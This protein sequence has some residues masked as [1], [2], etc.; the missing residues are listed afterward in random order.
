MLN[1]KPMLSFPARV[2]SWHA[3]AAIYTFVIVLA[4]CGGS[5][6]SPPT[7][8]PPTLASSFDV[9]KAVC[10]PG[11]R[12]E[13]GLQ[14]QIPMAER[15]GGF[16]G[17]NC[18]LEKTSAAPSSRGEGT[19]GMFALMHDRSGRTCGYTGGAF[20]DSIGTSVVDLTD[21]AKA[22]ETVVL[23]TAAMQNPGE[24]LRVHESRGLL[25]SAYYA[26]F[27][28]ANN[29]VQ[30]GFDVYDVGTDCRFPQ[31]L[32]S[33]TNLSFPA[34]NYRPPLIPAR[35]PASSDRIWGHEGAFSPDGLTYY[36]GDTFRGIY[37]AIDIAD[38][39]NPRYLSGLQ[40]PGYA[41]GT[42]FQ[43]LPHNLS[44]T[45]DGTRGYF[46]NQALNQR[47][48]GGMIPETGEWHNGFMV[49]DTSEIQ[50]RKPG[51]QMK[52]LKEVEIRDSAALQQSMAVTIRG[53][54][55]AIAV[56]EMG[57]GQANKAGIRSA[58]AAGK[59][60]FAMVQFFYMGDELN[61]QLVNKIRLEANDPKNCALISPDIDAPSPLG[62]MYDVHHCS[63]DNRDNATTLACGYFQSGIRV[64]DIR[65]PM[66]IKEIAYYVPP[67]KTAV[68]AWCGSL[69]VLEASTGMLYSWCADTGVV[70]MKFKNN[71]WPFW[72]SQ[73]PRDKQL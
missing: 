46:T 72:D 5:D 24:G 61:P 50:S 23:K 69:P 63:V 9:A 4:G 36:V 57:T 22:V 17:F 15:V 66:N 18:N 26:G 13:T 34:A 35:A 11:E 45:N 25:V 1:S 21:P 54:K 29:E 47:A 51:G 68:P 33:T 58:C 73:T 2:T 52:F 19:F 8:P 56:G 14:G 10:G 12:A 16:M 70:A 60:P 39:T 28:Q 71:I 67:A 41:S 7:A 44:L 27:A 37:H 48:P 62:F 43:G 40:G 32:A 53:N 64:Y 55:Y 30:H 6:A 31:L 38:P 3:T 20:L 49:V 59:T 65:D 42:G